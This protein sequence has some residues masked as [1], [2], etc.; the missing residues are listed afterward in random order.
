MPPAPA[1][2]ARFPPLERVEIEPLAGCDPAG[3]G[4]SLTH[5]S[6]RSLARIADERGIR[7]RI[8]HSTVSLILRQAALQPPRWRY[9]KTPTLNTEFRPRAARVLWG[10]ERAQ[11][12]ARRDEIVLCLDEKPNLQ[13]RE[14]RLPIES[15]PAGQIERREFDYVRH[16]TVHGLVRLEVHTGQMRAWCLERNNR[17]CLRQVLPPVREPYRKL[18]RLHLIGDGGASHVAGETQQFLH[19]HYPCV[20]GLL[21]PAQASWLDQAELLLRAFSQRYLH[22]GAGVSRQSMMEH[23]E[24]SWPEYNRLFARPFAW[25]WTRPQM[26]AWMDR[27]LHS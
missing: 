3:L 7:S 21:T 22:R 27:H 18:R 26:H 2:L 11:E 5:W 8:A 13:A 6:A 16:G 10:Y 15:L 4:L 24:A 9:W 20:R 19:E 14:R 12:L 1:V 25:S 17:A 23:M